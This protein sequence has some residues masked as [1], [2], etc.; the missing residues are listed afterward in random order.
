MDLHLRWRGSGEVSGRDALSFRCSRC[1]WCRVYMRVARYMIGVHRI[2]GVSR[3]ALCMVGHTR[4][5]HASVRLLI[6]V[7]RGSLGSRLS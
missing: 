2:C 4:R 3:Y 6:G 5:H 1:Q 7:V